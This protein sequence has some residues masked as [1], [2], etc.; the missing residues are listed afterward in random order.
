MVSLTCEGV[1][2]SQGMSNSPSFCLDPQV[3]G[4]SA[5]QLTA[6]D[7]F[8]R[9]KIKRPSTMVTSDAMNQVAQ[10]LHSSSS[11]AAATDESGVL[12]N[13]RSA[14]VPPKLT[15][16][17]S[18]SPDSELTQEGKLVDVDDESP[19]ERRHSTASLAADEDARLRALRRKRS[20]GAAVEQQRNPKPTS[21]ARLGGSQTNLPT[22]YIEATDQPN[23]EQ[24]SIH[25]TPR[26]TPELSTSARP[27]SQMTNVESIA[28]SSSSAN[29]S[30][31]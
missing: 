2:A 16:D 23:S 26:Q 3:R 27:E 20:G 6:S 15:T 8:S 4:D 7:V 10:A 21:Q 29:L 28:S 24:V 5:N 22:F 30:L 12:R 9:S 1:F 17:A 18:S 19:A 11:R 31:R 13:R 25:L 14:I